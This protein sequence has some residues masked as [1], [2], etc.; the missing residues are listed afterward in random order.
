MTLTFDIQWDDAMADVSSQAYRNTAAM[1]TGALR[2]MTGWQGDDL[3]HVNWIFTSG[4][5]VANADVP[6]FGDD[7]FADVQSRLASFDTNT[8]PKLISVSTQ[9]QT[10]KLL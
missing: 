9:E 8:I 5:V 3:S 2:T 4:S 1:A 10:G 7:T 6:I